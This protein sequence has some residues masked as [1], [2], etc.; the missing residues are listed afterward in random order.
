M[1]V[2]RSSVLHQRNRL[3]SHAT[4]RSQSRRVLSTSVAS[5]SSSPPSPHAHRKAFNSSLAVDSTV[6]RNLPEFAAAD[7]LEISRTHREFIT[8]K[9]QYEKLVQSGVLRGDDHQVRIVGKL[10][11]FWEQLLKY[12][13]PPIPE[14]KTSSSLVM[15]FLFSLMTTHTFVSRCL[16]C[17]LVRF[18][19][20]VPRLSWRPKV[21]IFMVTLAQ[22]RRCLWTSF[23]KHYPPLSHASVVCTSTP[24]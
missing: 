8:P 18:Q 10:Q 2:A 12:D 24:S 15:G 21:F 14:V 1:K 9:K 5:S 13:P 22:A 23:T 3:L 19:C 16:V 6:V 4:F 20:Q 11:H 7:Q 17:F